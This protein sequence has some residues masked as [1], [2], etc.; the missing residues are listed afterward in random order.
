MATNV[1]RSGRHSALGGVI[2][3]AIER[4]AEIGKA[5]ADQ[6]LADGALGSAKGDIR[7]AVFEVAMRLARYLLDLHLGMV[8]AIGDDDGGQ[9]MHEDGLGRGDAD[10]AR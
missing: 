10:Q 6:A 1:L 8:L 4:P 7:L 2:G 3:A 5:L 9:K